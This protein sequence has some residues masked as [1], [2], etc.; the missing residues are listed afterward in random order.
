M[1]VATMWTVLESTSTS[2]TGADVQAEVASDVP[3]CNAALSS[4]MVD[5]FGSHDMCIGCAAAFIAS[6]A[7]DSA[8]E[9]LL[10]D[11]EGRDKWAGE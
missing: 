4:G 2:C 1:G 6:G 9:W 11:T 5:P 3:W 8:Q 10:R 7:C